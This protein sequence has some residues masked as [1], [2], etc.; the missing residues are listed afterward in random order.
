MQFI[1]DNIKM[2]YYIK[3]YNLRD[4]FR[5]D[6]FPEY[7][8][9]MTLTKFSK[10]EYIYRQKDNIQFIYFFVE[11]KIKVCSLLSNAKSQLLY[12]YTKFGILGD[13]EL[14][15]RANPYTT[16]QAATDSYCIALSLAY[17][18]HLLY[19]DP[20]FLRQMAELLAQK[21]CNA[22]SNSSLN[23]YYSLENRLC[24]YIYSSAEKLAEDDAEVLVFK[25][26]LSETAEML[27]TSYRHLQR[28]LKS[29]REKGILEKTPN[30]YKVIN[31][32]ELMELSSDQYM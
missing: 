18:K 19:D 21:L 8:K 20:I 17:T 32:D 23:I 22:S 15:N 4:Y 14:F 1:D 31:V 7:L 9:Y 5:S 11:G 10:G 25:E 16:I 26:G 12:I 28:T 24:A 30:G 27:G 3:K 29:L 13:L 2:N 6:Y